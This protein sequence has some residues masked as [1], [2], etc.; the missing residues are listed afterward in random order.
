M[1]LK[2]TPLLVVSGAKF[3]RKTTLIPHKNDF[4]ISIKINVFYCFRNEQ[5]SL[6]KLKILK[7]YKYMSNFN[8]HDIVKKFK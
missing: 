6:K 3:R 5:R 4:E 2:V 7:Y 8:R 1:N